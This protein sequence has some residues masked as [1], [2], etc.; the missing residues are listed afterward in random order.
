MAHD[1]LLHHKRGEKVIDMQIVCPEC[2]CEVETS[3]MFNKLLRKYVPRPVIRCQ[4]H[5]GRT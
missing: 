4:D 2:G 5:E 3:V 1:Q